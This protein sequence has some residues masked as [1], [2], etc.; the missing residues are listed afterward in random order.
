MIKTYLLALLVSL[1]AFGD[2]SEP[3][4]TK[5]VCSEKVEALHVDRDGKIS[6]TSQTIARDTVH[7]EVERGDASALYLPILLTAFKDKQ[8]ICVVRDGVKVLRISL[9]HSVP[10]QGFEIGNGVRK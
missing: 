1:S 9:E 10:V 4:D 8:A 2:V 7:G 5:P 3:S 6:F